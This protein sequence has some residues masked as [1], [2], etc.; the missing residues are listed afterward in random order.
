VGGLPPPSWS[1]VRL[2]TKSGAGI[3]ASTASVVLAALAVQLAG[4]VP[5][6]SAAAAAAPSASATPAAAATP[7]TAAAAA[8]SARPA[9]SGTPASSVTPAAPPARITAKAAE[10]LDSTTGRRLWS[11]RLAHRRPIASI[12][13]VMTAL[14][15]LDA[16]RLERRLRVPAAAVS[17][18]R[19]HDAG[20]AGLHA[21]DVL[22]ARQLLEAMLLPSGADAA[23]TLAHAYGPGWHAFV[24]KMNATGRRLG[25]TN[26]HFANF[27]GLPY[28]TEHSTYATPQDL[29]LLA[30]AAMKS[31]VF[32]GIVHQRTHNLAP[33]SQHHGYSWHTTNLLL[34]RYSGALGIKTGYT[35]GAGYC[36]LFA[37]RRHGVTL[38]GVVLDSTTTSP[39]A[40]FTA[41]TRLLNWGFRRERAAQRAGSAG[42][43][44]AGRL[45]LPH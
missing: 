7:G 37:A 14:I 43:A 11:R 23:Y 42:Q 12:T 1:I 5:A 15:V 41:A 30:A 19:E 9:S 32:R 36:L 28:P 22:T 17:Y 8:S 24:A 35:T 26:F 34:R 20:S 45:E 16:P 33:T 2:L 10:L 39:G 44:R 4:P 21:G 13:K 27:D 18:A 3:A 29:L 6:P 40:R 31:A 25:L 38:T